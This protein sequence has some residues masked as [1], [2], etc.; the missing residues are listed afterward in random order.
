[1]TA[2]PWF[3]FYSETRMDMKILRIARDTGL[4]CMEVMGAWTVL[5]CI[6][7]QSPI[8]GELYVTTLK[9]YTLED[10]TDAFFTTRETAKMLMDAFIEMEMVGVKNDAFCITNWD[11]RQRKSDT[12]IERVRAFRQKKQDED[13]T[14]NVTET[15]PSSSTSISDSIFNTYS[16]EIGMITPK[17]RDELI[18]AESEYSQEWIITAINEASRQN[19]RSWAYALAILK[20]WK[21]EGFQSNTKRNGK[22][23]PDDPGSKY[24]EQGYTAA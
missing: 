19:K 15:L 11:K 22:S 6:A 24:R 20:R 21:V 7:N 23:N 3:R 5:L 10:V 16:R 18:D 2:M 9:R 12:S 13:D 14:C 17:I 8:R 1:M 4:N